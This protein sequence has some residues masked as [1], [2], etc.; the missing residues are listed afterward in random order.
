MKIKV[1]K[2]Q[3]DFI[4]QNGSTVNVNDENYYYIPETIAQ[5]KAGTKIE[6]EIRAI[7]TM[8]KN[9]RKTQKL[10]LIQLSEKAF[11]DPFHNKSISEIERGIRPQVSF[12]TICKIAKA[13]GLQ[14]I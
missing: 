4:K 9:E 5:R 3:S 12:I 14:V 8:L 10:S 7:G 13:L 1:T 2:E 11:G 6:R